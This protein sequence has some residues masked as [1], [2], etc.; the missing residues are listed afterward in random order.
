[1][2]HRKDIKVQRGPWRTRGMS[3]PVGWVR[4]VGFEDFD[5]DD[6]SL[7]GDHEGHISAY[8][9]RQFIGPE[10]H[11]HHI[12]EEERPAPD[13]QQVK[14]REDPLAGHG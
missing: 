5:D 1:M 3:C 2:R 6:P 12:P 11:A 14:N 10:L 13:G 9:E 4:P 7:T 8:M